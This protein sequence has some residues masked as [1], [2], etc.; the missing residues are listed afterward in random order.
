MSAVSKGAPTPAR[1][2]PRYRVASIVA[3]AVLLL[4]ACA[5]SGSAP[6]ASGAARP[7]AEASQP[8][9]PPAWAPPP[10]PAGQEPPAAAAGPLQLTKPLAPLSPPVTVKTRV[11]SSL[12]TGAF[13]YALEKGY[14]DQLGIIFEEVDLP[15]S[16]DMVP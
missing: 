2:C 11:G 8:P 12:T 15:N 9:P 7:P 3:A 16:N 10:A 4:G 13:W 1:R 5:P 6:P 14:F